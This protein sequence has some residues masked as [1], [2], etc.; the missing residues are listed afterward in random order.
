MI[1]DNDSNVEIRD[2]DGSYDGVGKVRKVLSLVGV[3]LLIGSVAA[4][5]FYV[6]PLW[7]NFGEVKADITSQ[8]EHIDELQGKIESIEDAEKKMDLGTEV[9]KVTLLNSIPVGLNQDEVIEDVIKIAGVYDIELRSIS[10]GLA[11]GYYDDVG[12][13]RVNASFEGNYGDLINFL[14][15]IEENARMLKVSSVNVQISRLEDL[16]IKRVTFSLSIDA[17]YL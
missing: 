8:E 1:D 16:D 10:F 3:V 12:V 4:Y 11:E 5:A 7:D 13:L 6:R 2:A 17:F 15:G 9:E 14:E